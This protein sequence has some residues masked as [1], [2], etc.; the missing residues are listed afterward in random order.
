[1]IDNTQYIIDLY[2]GM[3]SQFPKF[4]VAKMINSMKKNMIKTWNDAGHGDLTD[5]QYNLQF[6]EDLKA[7]DFYCE[8]ANKSGKFI[9]GTDKPTKGDALV[10]PWVRA[11][12][13]PE[14]LAGKVP[15]FAFAC[16]SENMKKYVE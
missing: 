3:F 12:L 15:A 1:M 4:M 7:L 8:Q 9:L 14:S 10:A 6:L 5:D 16:S 13:R 2:A 11:V